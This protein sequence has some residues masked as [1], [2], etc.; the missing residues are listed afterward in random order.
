[1]WVEVDDNLFPTA[2]NKPKWTSIHGTVL[3]KQQQKK[4]KSSIWTWI[5]KDR[6]PSWVI[7]IWRFT[8]GYIS[9][10]IHKIDK[11]DTIDDKRTI[12]GN[13]SWYTASYL[14]LRWCFRFRKRPSSVISSCYSF[15]TVSRQKCKS[16][17]AA[18]KASI[19]FYFFLIVFSFSLNCI[20]EAETNLGSI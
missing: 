14:S 13:S 4:H 9:I 10:K 6:L 17:L 20:F 8:I 3:K 12:L 1:M 18:H 11:L 7:Y 5:W 16:L 19:L 2:L 15:Y